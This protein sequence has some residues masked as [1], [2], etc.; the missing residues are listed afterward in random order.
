MIQSNDPWRGIQQLQPAL[1]VMP[2]E[3]PERIYD[4]TFPEVIHQGNEYAIPW[5]MEKTEPEPSNEG[6]KRLLGLSVRSFWIAV[7]LLTLILAGAIA[8]GLAG[9]LTSQRANVNSSAAQSETAT[10]RGPSTPTTPVSETPTATGISGMESPAPTD[11]GCPVI[12]GTTYTPHNS[13]GG[14][15]S[16]GD[17]TAPQ[18]FVQVCDTNWPAGEGNG[19][20]NVVDLL[21]AY[22][23]TLE[24][25]AAL[26]AQYNVAHRLNG[27]AT[28]GYCRSVNILKDVGGNCYLKNAVGANGV[29]RSRAFT[30]MK[31]L[32]YFSS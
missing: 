9:G 28:G 26:C 24:D 32:G 3:A 31:A 25:C 1:E 23:P 19:N 8:G 13:T 4:H 16:L 2:G 29:R 5:K 14:T 22:L 12:N 17:G 21:V 11:G 30:R 27:G 10:S 20:P 18:S 7:S 6:K 15:I